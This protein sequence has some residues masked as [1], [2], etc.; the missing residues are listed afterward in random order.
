MP[1]EKWFCPICKDSTF[2]CPTQNNPP[3]YEKSQKI[4]EKTRYA[5][6]KRQ[7]SKMYIIRE[8]IYTRKNNHIFSIITEQKTEVTTNVTFEINNRL[9][10]QLIYVLLDKHRY[11]VKKKAFW[12]TFPGKQWEP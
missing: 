9:F 12:K 4:L 5:D 7:L 10:I 3:Y 1:L 8:L 2:F 6:K 11:F